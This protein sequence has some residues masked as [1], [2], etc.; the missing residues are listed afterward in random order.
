MRNK[1][2][3]VLGLILVVYFVY[4]IYRALLIFTSQG[5]ATFADIKVHLIIVA[6]LFILV[7]FGLLGSKQEQAKEQKSKK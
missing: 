1:V 3:L 7:F 4:V 6:V 2:S 5:D